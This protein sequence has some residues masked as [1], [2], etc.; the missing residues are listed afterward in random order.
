MPHPPT[1]PGFEGVTTRPESLDVDILVIPV[2]GADDGL[3]D[4]S[5][6]DEAVGGDWR[7]AVSSREFTHRLYTGVTLRVT[8]ATWRARHVHVLGAGVSAEAT[9][10]RWRRFG[11][12]AGHL[13]R[14]RG[15]RSL[16]FL[17]RGAAAV[18][19]AAAMV[20]DG[21]S[22][23]EFD[24]GTY[25]RVDDRPGAAA[26]H[27]LIAA[28]G[29]DDTALSVAV[30]R[31]RVIGESA[32][33]A[34]GL[35]N[36]PG[37]VLTP[38]E[39]AARVAQAASA[40]GLAV[41]ILDEDRI[42][43]LG[44]GLLLAVAQGSAEPPRLMVLRHE[45]V[46]APKG[47][48]LALVGKGVTFDSGGISIKPAEAMDRMKDD[49]SGGAAVAAA[50]RAIAILD[51]PVRVLGVIPTVENMPGGRATRPGDVITG[52]SGTTVEI[53]NTD[54]EGRLILAD[55]LWYAQ[56]LGAT[57]LVDVAT[58]T[59]AVVVALGRTVAGLYGKPDAWVDRVRAAAVRSGD[60]VW[61][62]P[63]YE[64]AMQQLRSE[65]ADLSNVGGRPGGAS[66]AAAFLGAFT[67]DLPWAHLD[68]AGTAWAEERTSYQ[69]KGATGVAVRTL[70]ELAVSAAETPRSA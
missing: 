34:R 56:Q 21:I 54:A 14:Q 41:D 48:V 69:P 70:I 60:R 49:M 30:M 53:I 66:T 13:A 46:N 33:F 12:C 64:E 61:P 37:N 31:G 5:S 42:R 32:N 26:S 44:M 63:I 51:V 45:P 25:K 27:V 23:A 17:I 19:Q 39:F 20:A 24:G 59:G 52:A 65:I 1:V 47:P 18:E 3:V 35:A 29:A 55:A 43:G 8:S 38:T 28:P 9:A 7:R 16:A 11:S 40:V 10:E 36:E 58:L 15:A 62:M 68:I 2:F 57:H 22:A 4:V 6:L 50:M 67:G